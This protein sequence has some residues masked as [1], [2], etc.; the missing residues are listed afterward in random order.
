MAKGHL[1]TIKLYNLSANDLIRLGKILRRASPA[2]KS[3]YYSTTEHSSIQTLSFLRMT[4]ESLIVR[5][6]HPQGPPV[7]ADLAPLFGPTLRILSFHR[8]IPTFPDLY[9]YAPMLGS[10]TSLSITGSGY[11]NVMNL[12][13]HMTII[14]EIIFDFEEEI[15]NPDAFH[16]DIFLPSLRVFKLR[17]VPCPT[18]MGLSSLSVH[19]PMLHT[20]HLDSTS[21]SLWLLVFS[22]R[23]APAAIV[24]FRVDQPNGPVMTLSHLQPFLCDTIESFALTSVSYDLGPLLRDIHAGLILSRRKYLEFTFHDD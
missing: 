7:F 3:L 21:A 4:P 10:L 9:K 1:E 14:E 13:F 11:R 20:F 15:V 2:V 6:E 24:D 17:R 23:G 22:D 12:L 19:A 8:S 16:S 5:N 18:R